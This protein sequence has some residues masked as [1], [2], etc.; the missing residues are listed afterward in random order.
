MIPREVS[1]NLAVDEVRGN[2]PHKTALTSDTN[3]KFEGFPQTT[4][5][6]SNCYKPSQN[7]LETIILTFTVYY[8]ERIQIKISQGKKDLEWSLGKVPKAELLFFISLLTQG[9]VTFPASMCSST[10]YCQPRELT[11]R[12]CPEFL[13]LLSHILPMWLTFSLQIFW[14]QNW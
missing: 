11:E 5:K 13:L 12:W 14:R 7:S 4:L 9:W 10:E 8:R 2:S 3:C 6:F 1:K